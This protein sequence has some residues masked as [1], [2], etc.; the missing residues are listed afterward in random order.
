MGLNVFFVINLL[1][2]IFIVLAP[3]VLF[4]FILKDLKKYYLNSKRIILYF[5]AFVIVFFHKLIF[6]GQTLAQQDFNNLQITFFKFFQESALKFAQPPIWNSLT[7]GGYDA[8]ANPTAIYFSPFNLVFLLI[9]DVYV[10]ANL[11]MLLQTFFTLLFAFTFFRILRISKGASFLGATLLVFNAFFSLRLSP[12]VGIEYFFALKW[13]VLALAF[14]HLYFESF[15]KRYIYLISIS[16]AFMLE[17][18][19]NIAVVG[20]IF[21]FIYTLLTFKKL[22]K[23]LV[24]IAVFSFFVYSVKIIPALHLIMTAQGRIGETVQGWRTERIPVLDFWQ[25]FLPINQLFKTPMFTFGMAGSILFF[26]AI[27]WFIV[28]YRQSSKSIEYIIPSA[29]IFIIGAF[30]VT[31]NPISSLVFALPF[32]NRLTIL[33]AFIILLLIPSVIFIARFA[34]EFSKKF[35]YGVLIGL[36]PFVVFVEVLVGPPTI[37][38]KTYSFN[39][40]KMQHKTEMQKLEYYNFLAGKQKV[41]MFTDD[42]GLFTFPGYNA[43]LNV[44]TLN[45]FKYLYGSTNIEEMA[46]RDNLSEISKYADIFM[47][48]REMKT[49]T[50]KLG[51]IEIPRFDGENYQ[52]YAVMDRAFDYDKMQDFRWDYKIKLYE[53]LNKSVVS[54]KKANTHPTKHTFVVQKNN[55]EKN[56]NVITSITYSPF[57]KTSQNVK[58][59]KGAYGYLN[60][61]NAKIGNTITITYINPYIYLGFA[62]SAV[63]FCYIIIQLRKYEV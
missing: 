3:L 28:K 59:V 40:L 31:Q 21:W 51:E 54:V 62:I 48:A 50:K 36:V 7:G 39:F 6:F 20:G 37:G 55:F 9:K 29:I 61:E 5:A 60:I 52:N 12:G 17:G 63:A 38:S 47:A 34:D 13:I 8:F 2:L 33:P 10:A 58:L 46:Q 18:N 56:G 49:G 42:M 41:A 57:W 35:K 15:S 11:F 43:Y 30:L 1:L 32:F 4:G 24:A 27:I 25:Y 19:L 44:F 23:E 26:A 22:S 16:L 14:T 45:D 53:P